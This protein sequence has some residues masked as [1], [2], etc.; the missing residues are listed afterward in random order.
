MDLSVFGMNRH[1][2]LR[3]SQF[4]FFACRSEEFSLNLTADECEEASKKAKK[5]NKSL[6]S[7]IVR[8]C[9][10]GVKDDSVEEIEFFKESIG[11]TSAMSSIP[12][13]SKDSTAMV[14]IVLVQ[15]TGIS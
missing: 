3:K 7:I 1:I 11:S 13:L 12:T 9:T 10:S 2:N 8:V 4:R 15:A 6:G 5:K 14:H